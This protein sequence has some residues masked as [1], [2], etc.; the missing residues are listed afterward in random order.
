MPETLVVFLV[1]KLWFDDVLG[2]WKALPLFPFYIVKSFLCCFSPLPFFLVWFF[3]VFPWT[4]Q[5]H[6][7]LIPH[8]DDFI[9]QSLLC[10]HQVMAPRHESMSVV[11]KGVAPKELWQEGEQ[12]RAVVTGTLDAN[13]LFKDNVTSTW[14]YPAVG[15]HWY[16]HVCIH[17]N[18]VFPI[19]V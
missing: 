19:I 18:S 3:L 15:S 17:C 11:I 7:I 5:H 1:Y 12:W 16:W 8:Y 14:A 10:H 2:N 4:G 9:F 13:Q 6:G